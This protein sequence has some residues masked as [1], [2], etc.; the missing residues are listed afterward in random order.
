MCCV[1]LHCLPLLRDVL[2][3]FCVALLSFDVVC[4]DL[5]PFAWFCPVFMLFFASLFASSFG[6]LCHTLL[7]VSL[8]LFGIVACCSALFDFAALLFFVW[9][10]FAVGR[11]A[12]LCFV[13]FGFALF[14]CVS[15]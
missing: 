10:P 6:V 3:L 8:T 9:R 13:L 5:F 14:R 12:L 4:F 7:Y 1:A 15:S 2:L 11:F